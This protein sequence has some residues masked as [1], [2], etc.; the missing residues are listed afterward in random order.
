MVWRL[1]AIIIINYGLLAIAE[2]N[3]ASVT[4]AVDMKTPS[5]RKEASRRITAN[6]RQKPT[7]L[8]GE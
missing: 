4:A 6:S 2:K 1:F 7:P 3:G 5:T 8:R